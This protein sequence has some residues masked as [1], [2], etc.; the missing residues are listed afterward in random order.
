MKKILVVISSITISVFSILIIH[1][2]AKWAAASI[3]LDTGVVLQISGLSLKVS[4]PIVTGG[5]QLK[6]FFVMLS[7]LLSSIVFIELSFLLISRTSSEFTRSGVLIFQLINI[8]YLI[9]AVILGVIS[10]LLKSTFY[11]DWNIILE[12]ESL[13]YNQKLLLLFALMLLL[14]GYI[15]LL[16]KRVKKFIPTIK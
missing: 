15:N 4:F 7:P 5:I 10:L 9:F 12:N 1:Q 2:L 11:G 13:S 16:T 6:Y 3:L 8:G 14:L